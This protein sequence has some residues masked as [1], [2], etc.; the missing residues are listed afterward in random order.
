MTGT[1]RTAVPL[2][3][4]TVLLWWLVL[5]A[6]WSVVPTADP[7]TH[8]SPVTVGHWTA[9]ATGLAALAAAG[10]WARG[11]GAALLGV[12]L[13]AVALWCYRSATAEVIGAN[14]WPVGALFLAPVVAAGVAAVAA[15]GRTLRRRRERV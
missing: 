8:A 5:P 15:L 4:L 14:L 10:G 2:A 13:P 3:A 7:Q 9:A 11:P 6:D 12:A 1:L